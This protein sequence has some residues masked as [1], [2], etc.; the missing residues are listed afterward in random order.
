[1]HVSQK[2]RCEL[3]QS[4]WQQKETSCDYFHLNFCAQTPT[5]MACSHSINE[6]VP[7]LC[8]L[9]MDNFS[10]ATFFAKKQIRS[11]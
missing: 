1:M 10:I 2:H 7:N 4:R 6:Y 3:S 9:T 8:R 5:F 11:W